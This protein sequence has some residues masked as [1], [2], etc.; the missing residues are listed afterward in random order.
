MVVESE[1]CHMMCVTCLEQRSSSWLPELVRRRRS[2]CQHVKEKPG[3]APWSGSTLDLNGFFP[4]VYHTSFILICPVVFAFRADN[5]KTDRRNQVHCDKRTNHIA[6]AERN[7][8]NQAL[9]TQTWSYRLDLFCFCNFI[10]FLTSKNYRKSDVL[11]FNDP[12]VKWKTFCNYM[13]AE[14]LF[15]YWPCDKLATRL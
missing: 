1:V 12:I 8:L 3:S 10:L 15:V 5:W 6:V 4:G 11:S 14:G 7:K 9:A 13:S 2:I